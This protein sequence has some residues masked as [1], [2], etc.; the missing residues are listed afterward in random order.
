MD[1]INLKQN[2]ETTPHADSMRE[3]FSVK[4]RFAEATSGW[5]KTQK[6]SLIYIAILIV[7]ILLVFNSVRLFNTFFA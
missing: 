4:K 2:K 3:R 7:F 1:E 5:T 6:L